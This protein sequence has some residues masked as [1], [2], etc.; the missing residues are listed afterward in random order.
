V[1]RERGKRAAGVGHALLMGGAALKIAAEGDEARH[2]RLLNFGQR[3][4][5][6][7]HRAA[8]ELF[9]VKRKHAPQEAPVASTETSQSLELPSSNR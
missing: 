5:S 2:A 6:L 7:F 4:K 3:Y 9:A 1:R 8:P